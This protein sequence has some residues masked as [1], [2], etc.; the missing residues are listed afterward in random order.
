MDLDCAEG[1]PEPEP[2]P[3][4]D[5]KDE[6]EL[7]LAEEGCR[8]S[9]QQNSA[10]S[11]PLPYPNRP[12]RCSIG[13]LVVWR[14]PWRLYLRQIGSEASIRVKEGLDHSVGRAVRMVGETLRLV[15]APAQPLDVH[16]GRL[17]KHSGLLK[18]PVAGLMFH[19]GGLVKHF[20]RLE[21]P[22]GLSVLPFRPLELPFRL[23]PLAFRQ[24]ELPFRR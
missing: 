2:E 16:V 18:V 24:L 7:E 19:V 15:E 8:V 22:F 21:H 20:S 10:A 3:E 12:V 11:P 5:P 9:I 17:V 6:P 1:E 4:P 23:L 13:R 14:S